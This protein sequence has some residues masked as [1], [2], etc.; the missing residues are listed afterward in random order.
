M[1]MSRAERDNDISHN[2]TIVGRLVAGVTVESAASEMET[3][4][5]AQAKEQPSTHS[6]LGA[7]V[8]SM[9]DAA[10]ATLKRPL[11][12]LL[13]GV[14]FL[15][16]VAA[17]NAATLLLARAS[18]RHQELAVRSAIGASRGRLLSLAMAEALMLSTLGALAGAL[19]GSVCLELLLP[20]FAGV[21]RAGLDIAVGARGAPAHLRRARHGGADRRIGRANP[22]DGH[23]A[24][25]NG[26]ARRSARGNRRL[27]V[28]LVFGG[29]ADRGDRHPCRARRTSA[30]AC[31][32]SSPA[33][34]S[35]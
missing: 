35:R 7:R 15:I 8:V 19:L 27:R 33:G 32:A 5:A 2:S 6:G 20:L 31:S 16:L 9:S 3:I 10:S 17:A 34:R 13:A 21:L 28:D 11:L 4:A 30:V 29:A 1:R 24:A 23:A 26:A 18:E 22:R 12:V 14:A 25:R